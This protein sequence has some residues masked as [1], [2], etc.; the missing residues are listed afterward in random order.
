MVGRESR[1]ARAGHRP[2]SDVGHAPE[3][4]FRRRA[5]I[6]VA[7]DIRIKVFGCG[8]GGCQ[9]G[10]NIYLLR[11]YTSGATTLAQTGWSGLE[12]VDVMFGAT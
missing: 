8:W 7:S 11:S 4:Q 2:S 10:P 3:K 6:V 1:Q 9:E 12:S 5:I